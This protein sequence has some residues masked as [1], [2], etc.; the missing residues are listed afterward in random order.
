MRIDYV[1][2]KNF[3]QYAN[4]K[5]QFANSPEKNFTII[6]GPNGAGKTNLLNAITWCLFG[7]ELH[8]SKYKGLPILNTTIL[9]KTANENFVEV[10]VYIQFEKRNGKKI[11]VSR[12][13]RYQIK[14][15]KEIERQLPHPPPSIMWEGKRDWSKPIYGSDA[16]TKINNMI[17]KSIEEYFFFD[18]ERMNDYFKKNTGKDIK[19]AVNEISQIELLETMIKH[20]IARKNAF[21]SLAKGL[22]SDAKDLTGLIDCHEKSLI[23]DRE[24]LNELELKRTNAETLENE[25]SE[26]LKNSSLAYIKGLHIERN[27]IKV[28]ISG[29]EDEIEAVDAQELKLLHKNMPVLLANEALLT[30][31]SFIETSRAAGKIPPK[32]E[33]IFIQNLLDKN[34]CLCDSD[35]SERDKHSIERRKKVEAYL[36]VGR[37]PE[38]S[39]ELIETNALIREMLEDLTDFEDDVVNLGKRSKSLQRIIDEKK[40]DVK[41]ISEKIVKSEEDDV[42][43]WEI[44][45]KKNSD[46][47]NSLIGKIALITDRIEKRE[48]IIRASNSSL[49]RALRKEKKYD[50]LLKIRDFCDNSIKC[51]E[52]IKETIMKDVK[53][54]IEDKTS[55]QFLALIWKKDTFEGVVIDQNY[56]IS[57]PHVSGREALG[58][59]S[60]GETQ[61]CALSFMAAL[62]S[63]SGFDV[64]LII[65]TP[66]ARISSEPRVA[67]AKNLPD[68]LEG[69]QV[70]LLV[71]DEEYTSEVK[72]ALAPRVDKVYQID[73]EEKKRGNL[74][75]VILLND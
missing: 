74:A 27:K 73:V 62:N 18:G 13:I 52:E 54:E 70:T 57:V 49:D 56:N 6:K 9:E 39:T 4:V 2:M 71:T 61:V 14:D 44:E 30:T 43:K 28:E 50:S 15:R 3:R 66:L 17:P 46:L 60:A 75:K 10:N 68:Y 23:T 31:K 48:R 22:S 37:L 65:D 5:I 33:R 20:L 53:K 7:T 32:Y 26:K 40:A 51:A 64:P 11:L 42:R 19:T 38:I 69:K 55:Q 58:T 41:Q 8:V 67:I 63:V 59:L 12:G 24:E 47:N 1:E 16:Q 25:Y 21:S 36:D 29:L 72:N 34:K 35:I 45:R